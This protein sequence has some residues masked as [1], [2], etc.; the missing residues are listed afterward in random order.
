[1]SNNSRRTI[2][3]IAQHFAGGPHRDGGARW[4]YGLVVPALLAAL[5]AYCF[6]YQSVWL[7]RGRAGGW[8]EWTGTSAVL[9]GFVLLMLA[10]VGHCHSFWSGEERWHAAGYIAKVAALCG[11]IV[12]LFTLFF[13]EMLRW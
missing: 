4:I 3:D 10:A 7:P 2:F 12:A 11:L 13:H 1:M 6:Y 8:A 5:A 9:L